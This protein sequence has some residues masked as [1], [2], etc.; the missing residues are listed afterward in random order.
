MIKIY[1]IFVASVVM[2]MT[3][4]C[5]KDQVG[6]PYMLFEIHGKV[7][8][9]EGNPIGG[10]IV[11]SE[12]SDQQVTGMD[13]TFSFYGRSTPS[14]TVTL[15]FEDNDGEQNGGEFFDLSLKIPVKEKTPGSAVGNFR[16]TYFAGGVEVEMVN[17]KAQ[18]NPDSEVVPLS[19]F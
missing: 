17:K 10:I 9:A 19:A 3:A 8:D 13:G 7:V 2:M 5:S 1:R 12:K 18:V 15:S 4:A 16:G 6:D 11:S 14:A